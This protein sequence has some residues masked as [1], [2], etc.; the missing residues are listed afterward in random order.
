MAALLLPTNNQ[1]PK[2]ISEQNFDRPENLLTGNEFFSLHLLLPRIVSTQLL[3]NGAME[4]IFCERAPVQLS[5]ATPFKS[6]LE[7]L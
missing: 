5:A 2:E 7:G 6:L 3:N 1:Y 4:G